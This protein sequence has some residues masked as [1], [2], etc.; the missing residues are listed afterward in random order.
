M[1]DARVTWD[2]LAHLFA[3]ECAGSYAPASENFEYLWPSLN[4]ALGDYASTDYPDLGCPCRVCDFGC[5]TGMFAE[6]LGRSHDV[7]AIDVSPEMIR[8]ARENGEG[9]VAYR[10][11]GI[12]AMRSGSPYDFIL[13]VMVF[14]FIAELAPVIEAVRESLKQGGLLYIAVHNYG[15]AA[16]CM[17]KDAKF[18]TP[19]CLGVAGDDRPFAGEVRIGDA[20]VRTLLRAPDWY[21]QVLL[22]A[23]FSKVGCSFACAKPPEELEVLAD[24]WDVCKYYSAWYR[25]E[26]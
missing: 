25:K 5:G 19:Q 1:D 7:H 9:R 11:G 8:L 2:A 15:Y 26:G 24:E 16:K 14:Q 18:R 17:E 21:D 12:E 3:A 10:V 6:R 20:W 4:R 23:G 22:D 13:S